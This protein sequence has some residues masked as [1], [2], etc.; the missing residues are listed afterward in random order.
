MTLL[1]CS[2]FFSSFGRPE[3]V[4][5]MDFD[6]RMCVY[7]NFAVLFEGWECLGALQIR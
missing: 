2:S 1:F 6:G 5:E 7:L 4:Q 3:R